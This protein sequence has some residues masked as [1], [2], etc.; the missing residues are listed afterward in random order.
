MGPHLHPV[1]P[2]LPTPITTIALPSGGVPLGVQVFAFSLILLLR[3]LRR[4]LQVSV[5]PRHRDDCL[6]GARFLAKM[7]EGLGADVKVVQ[8]GVLQVYTATPLR[9]AAHS[10]EAHE[11]PQGK[12]TSPKRVYQVVLVCMRVWGVEGLG[13]A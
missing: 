6:K 4:P 1:P 5:S 2:I 13:A 10:T 12:R 11:G 7:L 9:R 8:V 3:F